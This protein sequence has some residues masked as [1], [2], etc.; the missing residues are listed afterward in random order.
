METAAGAVRRTSAIPPR[1]DAELRAAERG[2]ILRA[3]D[4]V[5]WKRRHF[6]LHCG[7]ASSAWRVGARV[8]LGLSLE[9]GAIR[10]PG[11]RL[12]CGRERAEASGEDGERRRP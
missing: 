1:D 4:D 9:R 2:E 8:E 10:R 6:F 5:T 3:V 12:L 7:E 11:C